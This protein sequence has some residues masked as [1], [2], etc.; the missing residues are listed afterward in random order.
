VSSS[1]RPGHRYLTHGNVRRASFSVSRA[2]RDQ[3]EN[4]RVYY[5]LDGTEVR[6]PE[7][8]GDRPDP[9]RLEWHYEEV[10]RRS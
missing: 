1:S 5:D 6:E 7:R 10:F 2:L 9:A 4:G 8:P 3:Y